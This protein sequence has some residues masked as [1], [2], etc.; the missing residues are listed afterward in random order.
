MERLSE[1][2]QL[3][4]ARQ[5]LKPQLDVPRPGNDICGLKWISS[6]FLASPTGRVFVNKT[7]ETPVWPPAARCDVL[8]DACGWMNAQLRHR[9]TGLVSSRLRLLQG[10][11]EAN[12]LGRA[13]D[14]GKSWHRNCNASSGARA[15]CTEQIRSGLR[16][17]SPIPRGN[18]TLGQGILR[19]FIKPP[20]MAVSTGELGWARPRLPKGRLRLQRGNNEDDV[21][22]HNPTLD[23]MASRQVYQQMTLYGSRVSEVE[24]LGRE[25]MSA[26]TGRGH[27]EWSG[28]IPPAAS[29]GRQNTG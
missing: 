15:P 4:A 24:K 11:R 21:T 8:T 28:G 27:P 25:Y 19:Y 5:D 17:S 26:N 1:L 13:G 9:G 29:T 20:M 6:P 2:L 7:R 10:R 18:N 3:S 16:K 14:H 22:S 12:M 23:V